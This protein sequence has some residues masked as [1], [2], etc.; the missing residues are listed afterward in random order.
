MEGIIKGS[1]YRV[2]GR[3]DSHV[4]GQ[5]SVLR[6][7]PVIHASR[8]GVMDP[9]KALL[10]STIGLL[11][12]L[13]SRSVRAIVG[14][15]LVSLASD[16]CIRWRRLLDVV[17]PHRACVRPTHCGRRQSATSATGWS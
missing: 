11:H 7:L 9:R 12:F 3:R 8:S 13:Q 2:D 17:G 10:N 14:G 4:S 16:T 6:R 1:V 15:V 5:S